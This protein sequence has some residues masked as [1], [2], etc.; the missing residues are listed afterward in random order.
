MNA[1]RLLTLAD[2]AGAAQVP[3]KTI[4]TWIFRKFP[5]IGDKDV[6]GGPGLPR[7]FSFDTTFQIAI[8]ADLIR[9]GSDIPAA[10]EAALRIVGTSSVPCFRAMAAGEIVPTDVRPFGG[11]WDDGR[12]YYVA[13]PA[14]GVMLHVPQ[15]ATV[16]PLVLGLTVYSAAPQDGAGESYAMIAL[17]PIYRRVEAVFTARG[18]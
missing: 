14:G 15:R 18:L 6:S 7:L 11:L 12:S 4:N 2:V 10:L 17:N 1:A 13:T 16:N 8:A 9:F 3:A 5:V